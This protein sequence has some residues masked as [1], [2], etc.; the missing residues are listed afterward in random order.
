MK[1]EQEEPQNNGAE[2]IKLI[3][4]LAAVGYMIYVLIK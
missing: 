3:L 4:G 1:E 2:A